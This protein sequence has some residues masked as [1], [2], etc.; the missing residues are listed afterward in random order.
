MRLPRPALSHLAWLSL[1]VAVATTATTAYG[2]PSTTRN[3]AA[4]ELFNQGRALLDAGNFAEACPKL[5]ESQRLD[6]TAGTLLN[7]ADCFEKNGQ[8]A[9][10]WV[11]FREAAR[12]AVDRRRPDWER[13][14]DKRAAALEPRL[15][16]LTIVVAPSARVEGLAVTAGALP[17]APALYDTGI[18][19]DPGALVVTARAPGRKEWSATLALRPDGDRQTL[20]IPALAVDASSAAA[21]T[22]AAASAER[23]TPH[24]GRGTPKSRGVPALA[25]LLG[26]GGVALGGGGIALWVVG[27]SEKS[28][29]DSGCGTTSS[30]AHGDIVASRSKLIVGDI[31]VGAGLLSLGAG[32]YIVLTSKPAAVISIGPRGAGVA[33]RF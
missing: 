14:A 5:A 1:A 24:E 4:E 26:A 7:L 2:Q 12:A 30:C 25:W 20:A 18:P 22:P 29:L 21:D 6:P 15:S 10:A 9:S 17:I 33:G 27:K 19:V 32:L 3:A 28:T 16:R 31:L 8:T 11:T 13:L 23:P